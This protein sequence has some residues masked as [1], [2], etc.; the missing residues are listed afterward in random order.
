M[1]A[2]ARAWASTCVQFV[3]FFP[4]GI[5]VRTRFAAAVVV[6]V[7]SAVVAVPALG[8]APGKNG[9]I[10]YAKFPRLWVINT[11]GTGARQLPHLKG[12]ED[13]DPDW[14]PNGS[15]VAFDRC[16]D[17][18]EIWLMRRDGTGVKRLGP[19]CLRS[20]SNSCKDRGFPAWSPDGKRIAFGQATL[21]RGKLKFAEIYVMNAD[22]TGA[23]QVTHLTGATPSTI[24]VLR[25]AWSPNG[26]QLVFEVENLAAADPP[27]RHAL[28]IDWNLN[29]GDDPDWSP[30]G[31]LIL[32][33]TI[34]RPQRHHGNLYTIQP[35]GTALKQLTRYQAPKTVLSGSFSP[36]GRWITLSRFSD[37][38]YPA[39][40]IMRAD[41]TGVR[42]VTQ[43]SA[44]YEPD[45]GPALGG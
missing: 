24:D 14:S 8:T 6:A 22:G 34:G 12:S 28:F 41:G 16:A 2:G 42:R 38:P 23:R 18:C 3:R 21:E 40:Y 29:A 11:D 1:V 44:A 13:S 7:V 37:G 31:K 43:D 30:D 39:V 4:E 32:F 5:R 17:R 35:D 26:K 33:R 36:D 27:N 25:P 45:W 19:N 10:A 15:R 20:R 9:Q